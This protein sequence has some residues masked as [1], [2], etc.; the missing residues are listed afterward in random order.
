MSL[1]CHVSSNEAH[2]ISVNSSESSSFLTCLSKRIA[3][4]HAHVS[5]TQYPATKI[6]MATSVCIQK[7]TP[8][9]CLCGMRIY[10]SYRFHA[11]PNW[12]Y[13]CTPETAN[14][15]ALFA[16]YCACSSAET[17]SV[18]SP[19]M[20]SN[21]HTSGSSFEKCTRFFGPFGWGGAAVNR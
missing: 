6:P 18:L 1:S 21:I 17:F 2:T 9:A 12:S 16:S 3:T 8:I 7:V 5:S 14:P 10:F 15:W 4:K 13:G 11:P 20:L 19:K